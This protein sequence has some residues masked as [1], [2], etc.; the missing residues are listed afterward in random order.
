MKIIGLTGGI[1]TGKSSVS[2]HLRASGI[3]VIDCDLLARQVVEPGTPALRSIVAT[4]GPDVLVQ[5]TGVLDRAKLGEL[6]FNDPAKR[7]L[8][9]AITH[10]AIRRAILARVI[11]YWLRGEAMVVVD[12]PLLVESG[13]YKWMSEVVVVYC[14]EEAQLA[15]LMHR[16][17]LDA[18][19]ARARISAQ[20]PMA[21]KIKLATHVIDNAG[22]LDD[23]YTQVDALV[24][25]LRPRAWSVWM[26]RL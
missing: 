24:P 18:S 15:R 13:L 16:D 9:N 12:A 10:P 5:P 4:F 21:D 17:S 7:R 22:S 20:A 25:R 14:P 6:I 3:P 11:E 2:L 23:L 26:W 1:A 8:L 19:A